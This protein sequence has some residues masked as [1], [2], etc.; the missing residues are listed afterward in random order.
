MSGLFEGGDSR[1]GGG[2]FWE[3]EDQGWVRLTGLQ[4]L[5]SSLIIKAP[6]E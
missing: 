3:L 6:I 4:S 1:G 2:L 5:P